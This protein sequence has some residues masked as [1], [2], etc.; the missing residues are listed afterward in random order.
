MFSLSKLIRL[1]MA[2][3]SQISY[4]NSGLSAFAYSEDSV[5]LIFRC[6]GCEV[7]LQNLEQ[8][9]TKANE[10]KEAESKESMRI[11]QEVGKC[12]FC[13]RSHESASI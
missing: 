8:Q 6:T 11:E 4:C 1:L 12:V 9:I 2:N 7:I 13:S 5:V 3:I 10:R